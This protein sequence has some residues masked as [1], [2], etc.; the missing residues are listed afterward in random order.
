[1]GYILFRLGHLLAWSTFTLYSDFACILSIE[2]R[3]CNKK[4]MA[5][6]VTAQE[7]AL[8]CYLYAFYLEKLD[9]SVNIGS[10]ILLVHFCVSDVRSEC[11]FQIWCLQYS[12]MNKIFVL[13][14]GCGIY[15]VYL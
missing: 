9:A 10:T 15:R 12:C 13:V 6:N 11:E 7:C 1:M 5:Q 14:V 2:E 4:F 3:C 8:K